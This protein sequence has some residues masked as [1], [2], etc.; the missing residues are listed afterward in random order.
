MI[1]Q[2]LLLGTLIAFVWHKRRDVRLKSQ[3]VHRME[4][5]AYVIRVKFMARPGEQFILRRE[6]FRLCTKPFVPH[7]TDSWLAQPNSSFRRHP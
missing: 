1:L 3:G 7:T 6:V 4:A 5:S 2:W